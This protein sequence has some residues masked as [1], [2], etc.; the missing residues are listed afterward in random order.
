[1][2]WNTV[3]GGPTCHADIR[4]LHLGQGYQLIPASEEAQCHGEVN[5]IG[6]S[7]II[8]DLALL[9]TTVE[10]RKFNPL[11]LKL[12]QTIIWTISW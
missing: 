1:M 5:I 2:H 7:Y 12:F 10:H 9:R 11:D 4:G 6:M 8:F 3:N